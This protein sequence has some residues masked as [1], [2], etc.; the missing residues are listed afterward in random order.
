MTRAR[1]LGDFIA[2][3]AAA[4]LVV[5]TTTLVVDSTN[6]RVGIGTASPATALDVVGNATITV[7]DNSDALTIVST[8]AD[9]SVGPVLNLYRNSAS[10]ADNDVLGRIIFKGED[11]AG[12]AATFARIEAIATDVSNGSE[13]GRID[14]LT[15]KDDAFNVALSVS[16]NSALAKR[17]RSNT[18]GDAAL[19]ISPSD[20]VVSYGFRVDS[21][22][23]NLN[24][25]RVDNTTHLM[26]FD[27]SGNFIIGETSTING[28]NLNVATSAADATISALCRSTTDS[29]GVT[30]VL[31]KSSTNSGNFA[32]TADGEN[33]GKILFR[34][35]NTSTVSKVGAQISVVQN[36][37]DSSTV[38]ADMVFTTKEAERF[39]MGSLG[40]LGIGGATYGTSGQVLTSGG[41]SAAPTW[42]DAAG[43]SE[44]IRVARTSDTVLTSANAGNLIDITSGTFTQT[45]NASSSLGN[46]WLAYIRNSGTGVITLD[47]NSSET[48][49]GLST[50][51]IYPGDT[52]IVQCDGSNLRTIML[53]G[54]VQT[55]T[56]SGS[57]IVPS[58]VTGLI[59][60]CWG[61]G[62][63][64]GGGS[65]GDSRSGAGGGGG[66]HAQK[67][68]DAITAGTSITVTVGAGGNAGSGNGGSGGSGGVSSFSTYLKAHGGRGGTAQGSGGAGSHGTGQGGTALNEYYGQGYPTV[69]I[70]NRNGGQFQSDGNIFSQVGG[71]GAIG[72]NGSSTTT[73]HGFSAE[74]GGGS[75]AP[76][77][78]SNRT[79]GNGGSSI[80]GGGGG[81]AGS[82]AG[83][84]PGGEGGGTNMWQR[85]GGGTSG[86]FQA[87]GNGA[88]GSGLFG[89]AGGG[90]GSNAAGGNGGSPSGAGGGG[91]K[92]NH[93]GG[94]GGSGKIIVTYF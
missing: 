73:Y 44:L 66:A 6:N 56:S 38:P 77:V 78:G 55:F 90:G 3:G 41:A 52:R 89:G 72:I 24:L 92:G 75:G 15:A 40:Q 67:K 21:S 13:D 39:R 53:K 32:A 70:S 76:Y 29:H 8:D 14:F 62:G 26:T 31:Q 51:A 4:E 37:T 27:A 59:V 61:G 91:G 35:V 87:G 49:D 1:D 79:G 22:N 5:D 19:T 64:G 18:A 83:S 17:A 88:D 54:G 45:F 85:G 7:A 50:F 43:G 2:D 80:Y 57:F 69:N 68:L 10:P 9:A 12:N 34:G 28:G 82:G 20:T 42:A 93:A 81:G 25:D 36:G 23:N 33:L 74:W 11:D 58:H 60:D 16:G 63:G 84:D 47:P 65:T 86:T 48:I 30:V 71:G 94:S 46:G